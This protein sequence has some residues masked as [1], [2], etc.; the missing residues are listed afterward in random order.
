MTRGLSTAGAIAFV[1]AGGC[2]TVGSPPMSDAEVLARMRGEFVQ[3][4]ARGDP[5][6]V[7]S[8]YAPNAVY[9]GTAGDV[10]VGRDRLLVGLRKELPVFRKFSATPAELQTSGDMAFERG[11]YAAE[12][13]IPGR[14]P[15]P[16]TG[17]YLIVY[18]RQPDGSWKIRTHMTNRDR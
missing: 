3:A 6:A 17:E 2:S 5:D 8:F 7:A 15:E 10:V 14:T 4:Y 11:A 1:L 9:I 13:S 12:L 16:L 18:R